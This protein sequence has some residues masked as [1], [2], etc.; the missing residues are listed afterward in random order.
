M[1]MCS[2]AG[3]S[4]RKASTERRSATMTADYS[5]G[6][7]IVNGYR[8]QPRGGGLMLDGDAVLRERIADCAVEQGHRLIEIGPRPQ[9][10]SLRGHERGLTL[11]HQEDRAQ[12]RV[13][14]AALA[15][16]LLP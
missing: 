11:Q 6:G 12:P 1:R 14:P 9:F 2:V 13:E 3:G 4:G 5:H 10:L 16:V 8:R 15:F 7:C